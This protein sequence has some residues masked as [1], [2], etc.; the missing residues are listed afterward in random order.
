MLIS[1]AYISLLITKNYKI[2]IYIESLKKI[3]IIEIKPIISG[4]ECVI[5]TIILIKKT[6]LKS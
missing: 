5:K 1:L 6:R 2:K 4:K 3:R